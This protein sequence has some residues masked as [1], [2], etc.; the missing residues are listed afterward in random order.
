MSYRYHSSRRSWEQD[1]ERAREAHAR[2]DE[3]RRYTY[4]DVF[5]DP[6]RMLAELGGLLKR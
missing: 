4:R 1:Y 6:R 2:G 5:E 3:F